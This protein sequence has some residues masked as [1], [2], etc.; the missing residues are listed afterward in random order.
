MVNRQLRYSAIELFGTLGSTKDN[1]AKMIILEKKRFISMLAGI[2]IQETEGDYP[3]KILILR[4]IN[5]F[6]FQN[7][8]DLI[9]EAQLIKELQKYIDVV[10]DYQKGRK[11]AEEKG[12]EETPLASVTITDDQQQLAA[13]S[14]FVIKT[15]LNQSTYSQKEEIIK[16]F[17][18]ERLKQCF[19]VELMVQPG[20]EGK[21]NKD[22]F[23][24]LSVA[25]LQNL[26]LNSTSE[27]LKNQ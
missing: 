4:A 21:F 13:R 11:E 27:C 19:D 26:L 24:R 9:K 23:K 8:K 2:L 1:L 14:L 15:S 17:G 12:G 5:N 18:W 22:D 25:I 16:Q 7:A 20:S 3:M 10:L 6:I